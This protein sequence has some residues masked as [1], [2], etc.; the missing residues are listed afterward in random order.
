MK[1]YELANA[2]D[3][4]INGGLVFDEETGEVLFDAESLE[5]L[6]CE[7]DQKLEAC[8]IVIKETLAEA[9]AIK[10]EE[11]RLKERRQR[12]EKE[13]ERLKDYVLH[14]MEQTG[15]RKIDT[16]RVALS[17]RKSETVEVLNEASVPREFV[18]VKTTE[19]VDKAAV[20]KAI[21]A[22]GNV[23]GCELLERISLQVK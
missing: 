7:L 13:A 22:G 16:A 19:A 8:G 21:K 5:A 14:C 4:V 11:S 15:A 17:T 23:A 20:K 10:A 9:E 18:K 2:M 3:A 1:L 6:E 12:K